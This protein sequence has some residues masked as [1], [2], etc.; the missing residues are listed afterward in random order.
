MSN[1]F[2][3]G[4]TWW[5][6]VAISGVEHRSSL[7]TANKAEAE[8]RAKV[9]IGRLKGDAFFGEKRLLWEE[10]VVAW[11]NDVRRKLANDENAKPGA[12]TL[13]RYECSLGQVAEVLEGYYAHEID[14]DTIQEIIDTRRDDGATNRTIRN[15]LTAVSSVLRYC[16]RNKATDRNVALD[17]VLLHGRDELPASSAELNIPNEEE[18]EWLAA[19][20]PEPYADM[21]R[22]ASRAGMRLGEIVRLERRNVEAGRIRLIRTKSKKV[23]VLDLEELGVLDII[24]RQPVA[25]STTCRHIFWHISDEGKPDR[26]RSPSSAFKGI[27]ERAIKAAEREGRDFQRF[28]FHDLRHFSAV[29]ML[30][31]GWSVYDVQHLLGHSSV[32]VTERYFSELSLQEL[33]IA[34]SASAQFSAHSKRFEKRDAG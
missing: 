10:A 24:E 20:A 3:R 28:R 12:D 34:Q 32:K 29:S 2:K 16:A 25:P 22:F 15:D 26:Y 27:M 11:G 7:R 1:I 19:R 14:A 9:E 8:A 18:I 17:Y 6:R 21:I 5:L 23:R 33:R 4:R 30:R 31:R 13:N